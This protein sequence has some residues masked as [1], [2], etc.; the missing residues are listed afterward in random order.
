MLFKT[1][2]R[3]KLEYNNTVWRCSTKAKEQKIEVGQR[4]ATNMLPSFKN[5]T[6]PECLKSP[7]LTHTPLSQIA[8]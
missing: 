1:L 6:C 3:S 5:L 2:I 7:Y 8:S 4:R